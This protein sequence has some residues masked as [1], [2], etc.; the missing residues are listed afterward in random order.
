MV[1]DHGQR[2]GPHSGCPRNRYKGL[3]TE[4]WG[5]CSFP[6]LLQGAMG[7]DLELL[8]AEELGEGS[9]ETVVAEWVEDRVDS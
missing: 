5:S 2:Q 3:A 9:A 7:L 6:A 1:F 8:G 4:G